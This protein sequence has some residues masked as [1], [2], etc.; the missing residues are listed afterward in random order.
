MS[1]GSKA[2]LLEYRNNWEADEFFLVNQAYDGK[3]TN[4]ERVADLR[5]VRIH[6]RVYDV[7]SRVISKPYDDMG[8][9]FHGVSK[10]YFVMEDVFGKKVEFDLGV[11]MS[12]YKVV[13]FAE[14][15]S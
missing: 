9:T 7:T 5:K 15:W 14:E 12:K 3:K 2:K 4:K 6:F 8:R 10:H 13:A 11:L 1:H